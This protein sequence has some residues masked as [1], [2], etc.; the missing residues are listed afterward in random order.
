MNPVFSSA[1]DEAVEEALHPPAPEK[2]RGAAKKHAE[3][4]KAAP[5]KRAKAKKDAPSRA[6][7][8]AGDAQARGEVRPAGTPGGSRSSGRR[9][10][11]R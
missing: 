6:A 1:I 4:K 11:P 9:R 5:Q 7:R 2:S 10:R 3:A 8:P